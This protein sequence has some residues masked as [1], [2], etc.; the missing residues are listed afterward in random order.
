MC[1]GYCSHSVC[2]SVIT[3]TASFASPRCSVIT[4]IM[5][6]Q[7]HD[8]CEFCRKCFVGQFWRHLLILSFLTS[9]C[10]VTL[11]INRT[12]Y[13][14]AGYEGGV[15]GPRDSYARSYF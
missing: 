1:E 6:F 5:A 13:A 12:L 2:L 14:R 8:L 11:R 9:F 15:W 4:F 7:M 10:P 3:L